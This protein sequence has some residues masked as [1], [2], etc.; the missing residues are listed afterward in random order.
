VV[1]PDGAW[2]FTGRGFFHAALALAYPAIRAKPHQGSMV[3]RLFTQHG[4][5]PATVCRDISVYYTSE[6]RTK[7]PHVN[8]FEILFFAS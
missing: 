4:E 1:T 5:P 8:M 6:E 2:T 3:D 7:A